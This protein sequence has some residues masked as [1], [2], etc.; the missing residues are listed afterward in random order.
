[1]QGNTHAN[2]DASS[3]PQRDGTRALENGGYAAGNGREAIG[4]VISDGPKMIGVP[5]LSRNL[6]LDIM[7]D[8]RSK[9]IGKA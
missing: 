4:I 2:C 1:M 6:H 3:V 8:R 5:G 7:T 9:L